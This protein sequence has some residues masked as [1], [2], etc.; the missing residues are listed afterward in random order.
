[1][2]E[3]SIPAAMLVG[4][5]LHKSVAMITDGRFSGATRG[6]CVGHISPEAWEKGPI[7]FVKDGDIIEINIPKS[8][9]ELEISKEE[10][11]RRQKVELELP[12]H[13]APGLLSSYRK[14]VGKVE[15][16]AIWI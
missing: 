3:L 13:N 12:N 11:C 5:G 14:S 7:A 9:I 8:K 1:M 2:R 10:L 16:G 6:P 15:F 4:M